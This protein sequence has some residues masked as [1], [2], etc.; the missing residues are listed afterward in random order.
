MAGNMNHL[1]CIEDLATKRDN[2]D[3]AKRAA[4]YSAVVCDWV[5]GR[6]ISVL[7]IYIY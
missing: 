1:G 6:L 4:N 5:K 2:Y 3:K 7:Y